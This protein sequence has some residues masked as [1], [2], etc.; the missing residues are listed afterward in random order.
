ML[1]DARMEMENTVKIINTFISV[2]FL[3]ATICYT[4]FSLKL[5]QSQS[6]SDYN[7]CQIRFTQICIKYCFIFRRIS[8]IFLV[9]VICFKA[10][11]DKIA[12]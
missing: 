3:R 12:M 6:L 11:I 9:L 8:L 10:Y 5:L 7:A 4:I 1:V 2:A